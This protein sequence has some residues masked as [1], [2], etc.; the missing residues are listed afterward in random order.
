MAP[1]DSISVAWFKG[2]AEPN[3]GEQVRGATA[4]GPLLAAREAAWRALQQ[5]AVPVTLEAPDGTRHAMDVD[6]D[7][8]QSMAELRRGMLKGYRNLLKV[9]LPE[10]R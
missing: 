8:L 2:R 10:H 3:E 1:D 7:G 5:P 6:L 9:H 4:V